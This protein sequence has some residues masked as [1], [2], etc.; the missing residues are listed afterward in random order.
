MGYTA[1][2]PILLN[3]ADEPTYFLS[4]KD[5]A[6]LV[7]KYAMVNIEK[8]HIVAIGDTVA[9]CEKV[10]R[11]L[12]ANSGINVTPVSYTHLGML[13]KGLG[14]FLQAKAEFA[15]GAV[16]IIIG[17]KILVEHIFLGG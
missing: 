16:L 9:E 14:N 2:F 13:G 15:G 10:Y 11:N 6:G 7:K 4:L 8:Y 3:I 17:I 5:A 1:T 12:M